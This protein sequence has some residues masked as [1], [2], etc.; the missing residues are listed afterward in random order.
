MPRYYN[1]GYQGSQYAGQQYPLAPRPTQAPGLR[2]GLGDEKADKIIEQFSSPFSAIAPDVS[3]LSDKELDILIVF[4]EEALAGSVASGAAAKDPTRLALGKA[5]LAGIKDEKS[6]RTRN[7][8][9]LVGA[10]GVGIYLI[11]RKK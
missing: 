11:T 8:L 2:Y 7:K 1:Y 10:A 3:K 4:M 5:M 6:K 9:L